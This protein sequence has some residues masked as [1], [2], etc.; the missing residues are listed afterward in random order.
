MVAF[1]LLALAIFPF[2][3]Q[4]HAASV[5]IY[6]TQIDVTNAARGSVFYNTIGLR[7][8][9]PHPQTFQLVAQGPIADWVEFV[10]AR[11]HTKMVNSIT[12]RAATNGS[13]QGEVVSRIS[14]PV[15]APN[16]T[17]TGSILVTTA[18]ERPQQSASSSASV[19]LG[20]QIDVTVVV[21][22]QQ[23]ISASLSDA[24]ALNIEV[25]SPLRIS[26]MMHNSGNIRIVP[27]FHVVVSTGTKTV[28]STTLTAGA[29][30]PAQSQ[31]MEPVLKEA[32]SFPTGIY[33]ARVSASFEDVDFGSKT[34]QFRVAPVGTYTRQG[35]L[36]AMKLESQPAAGAVAKINVTFQNT[37]EIDSTAIFVGE[38]KRDG[39]L[40]QA[41]QSPEKTVPAGQSGQLEVFV[42]TPKPGKYSVTG[43]VNFQGKETE[44]K[45]LSFT[46][47]APL[48]HEPATSSSSTSTVS[49]STA[50]SGKS[51]STAGTA[52]PTHASTSSPVVNSMPSGPVSGD[53]SP[54]TV[55]AAGSDTAMIFTGIG[56]AL[57]LGAL[58]AFGWMFLKRRAQE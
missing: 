35:V 43:K 3:R 52:T 18:L 9:E 4:A 27:Q 5:G 44:T 36:N 2:A 21:T 12:V 28:A 38:V 23:T 14:V 47:T 33:D 55:Q 24:S 51:T 42:N 7:H 45:S 37:G 49:P 10:D 13:A 15:N 54:P 31:N 32:T 53:G 22:G 20:A 11:D 50:T 1:V 39:V 26:T 40:V 16:G 57:F 56:V 58:G 30:D 48:S 41:I 25:G 17:Y 46:V 8:S 6:P 19:S 29:L 34:F